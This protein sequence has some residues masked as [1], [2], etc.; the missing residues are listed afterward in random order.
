MA[1][2]YPPAFDEYALDVLRAR[3]DVLIPASD[4]ESRSFA[5]NAVVVGK[6][7]I[8]NSGCSQLHR[9]LQSHGFT[10]EE[11]PLSEFVKAG[12]S[13]KCLTLRLDGEEA[14]KARTS[15]EALTQVQQT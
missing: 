11:C 4:E 8:T 13:A 2:Y 6:T 5:C 3:I 10:T 14:A 15:G 9:Q 7:V 12:G 1:I